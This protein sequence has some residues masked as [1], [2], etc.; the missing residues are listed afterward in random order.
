MARCFIHA[1]F[2]YS[3]YAAGLGLFLFTLVS[4]YAAGSVVFI[5]G[6]VLARSLYCAGLPNLSMVP[7]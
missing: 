5:H 6:F 1:S 4:V 7:W 2:F 3:V